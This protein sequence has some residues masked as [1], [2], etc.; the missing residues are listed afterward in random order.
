MLENNH[1]R[2]EP[3]QCTLNGGQ[4]NVMPQYDL[5]GS[6][7]QLGTG[8]RVQNLQLTPDLCRDW[9]G[10]VAP[11][12]AD[13]ADVSGEISARVERF[14]WDVYEPQNSDV[15]AQLTI[16][17][18]Q[19]SAGSSLLPLLEVVDLLRRRGASDQGFAERSL[20][21][22]EQTVPIQVRQGYVIHDGLVMELNGYRLKTAGAVGL[23]KQLQMTIDVPLE[24]T[25]AAENGRS[26]KVPLRGTISQPQP[27]TS[28][29]LQNLGTQKIQQKLDEQVD[30]TL[31]KQLNKLFDKF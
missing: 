13:S 10:Y 17:R 3:I 19:A 2:S 25:T 11:M 18:A 14:L 5:A 9:L 23:N 24:K 16:H 12:I 6:R 26:V 7:L 8:S 30:K 28:A 27:D 21:L 1:L 22:P 15:M 29:L 20:I 4:L 31:N